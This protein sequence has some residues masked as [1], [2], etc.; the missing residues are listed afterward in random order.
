MAARSALAAGDVAAARVA[1]QRASAP[2]IQ[3]AQRGRIEGAIPR[4]GAAR[5]TGAAAVGRQKGGQ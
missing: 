5:L 2:L 4:P 3:A 1:L